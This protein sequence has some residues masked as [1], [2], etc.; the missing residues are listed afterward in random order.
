MALTR[1]RRQRI[2]AGNS[3]HLRSGLLLH[4]LPVSQ[5]PVRRQGQLSRTAASR[6]LLP[7]NI[8]HVEGRTE[9][10]RR[11]EAETDGPD[12]PGLSHVTNRI[13]QTSSSQQHS[14][15]LEGDDASALNDSV[16]FH[17][18]HGTVAAPVVNPPITAQS[19]LSKVDPDDIGV[20][21]DGDTVLA[22]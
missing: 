2:Q 9:Q 8:G 3:R 4:A 17:S 14:D 7:V 21:K 10:P 19:L 1:Q 13:G 6:P 11:S 20:P 16:C 15:P 22:S 5:H 12:A 18:S